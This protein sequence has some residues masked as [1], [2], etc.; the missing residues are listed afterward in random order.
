MHNAAICFGINEAILV[1]RKLPTAEIHVFAAVLPRS[2]QNRSRLKT[3]D[4]IDL[5]EA[6]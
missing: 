3:L 1:R 2:G 6:S 4:R 5:Q